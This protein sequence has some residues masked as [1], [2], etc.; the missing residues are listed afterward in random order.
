VFRR[1]ASGNDGSSAEPSGT[2][3]GTEVDEATSN[4]VVQEVSQTATERKTAETD[5]LEGSE[6][7]QVA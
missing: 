6:G 5:T 7:V 3:T 1:S 4:G 2:E